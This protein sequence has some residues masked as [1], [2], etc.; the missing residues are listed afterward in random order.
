MIEINVLKEKFLPIF[1]KYKIEKAIL[2]GSF[3]RGEATR[4]SDID[5]ILIQ[6]TEKRFWDRY[7]GLLLDCGQAISGRSVDLL[8]YTSDELEQ[9]KERVFIRQALS[10]GVTLY[11]SDKKRARSAP[12]ATNRA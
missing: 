6:E 4:R 1:K 11:E 7:D 2:F 12:L 3:A 8:I 10:E 5:L 9:I